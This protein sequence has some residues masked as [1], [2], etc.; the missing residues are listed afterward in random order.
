MG[1]ITYN[2]LRDCE[3]CGANVTES[4]DECWNCGRHINWKMS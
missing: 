3:G 2:N 1:A 4:N